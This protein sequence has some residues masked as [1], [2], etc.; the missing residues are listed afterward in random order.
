MGAQHCN[1]VILSEVRYDVGGS[2]G[3]WVIL[4]EVRLDVNGSPE[5]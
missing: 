4:S 1:W 2:Q 5:L 3:I